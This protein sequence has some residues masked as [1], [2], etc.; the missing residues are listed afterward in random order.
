MIKWIIA[1]ILV[2]IGF[3]TWSMCRVASKADR[4]LEYIDIREL[5]YI[6]IKKIIK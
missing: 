5:N 6:I 2:L 3:T 4:E 1:I